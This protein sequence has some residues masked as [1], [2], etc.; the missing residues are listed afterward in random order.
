MRWNAQ[1]DW[2]WSPE[3]VHEALISPEVFEQAR[4]M[5]TPASQ[6]SP[7]RMPRSSA[8]NPYLLRGLVHCGLCGRRMQGNWNNGRPHYRCSMPAEYAVGSRSDH[9]K[10]VYVREAQIVAP[11]D[12]W[13]ADVFSPTK[14]EA[15]VEAMSAADEDPSVEALREA[16]RQ[17]LQQCDARLVKYRTALDADVDAAV[18]GEWIAEVQADRQRAEAALRRVTGNERMSQAQIRSFV[19]QLAGIM[20]T[21]DGAD[22]HDRAAVYAQLGLRLTY[23]PAERIVQAQASPGGPCVKD[24]VRGGT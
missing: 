7:E 15:T 8:R 5:L 14:V 3:V 10:T 20:E 12:R 21:L 18:V 13:L 24:R 2:I 9:P 16:A 11:L 22:P 19:E 17:T 23:Q 1:G 4:I 6:R